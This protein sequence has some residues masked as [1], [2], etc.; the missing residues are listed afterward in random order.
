LI[1]GDSVCTINPTHGR[2]PCRHPRLPLRSGRDRALLRR[3]VSRPSTRLPRDGGVRESD[4]QAQRVDRTAVRGSEAVA[5][6]AAVPAAGAC[7]GEHGGTA[8][9]GGA[10]SQAAIERERLGTA[11]VAGW[12]RRVGRY[13]AAPACR[14]AVKHPLRLISRP[15]TRGHHC[16]PMTDGATAVSH[17]RLLQQP[18]PLC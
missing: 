2:Y 15:C 1:R 3:R 11:P 4:A 9:R 5:W 14:N 13:A 18:G 17:D 12:G 16:L 10:E 8:D 7:E 6:A